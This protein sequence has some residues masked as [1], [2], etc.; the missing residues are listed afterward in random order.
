MSSTNMVD[1]E[2]Q[3]TKFK[4]CVKIWETNFMKK[5][6]RK[7]NKT[8]INEAS[9]TIRDAYKNY[10]TLKT[11]LL[12]NTVTDAMC[13]IPVENF[14]VGSKNDSEDCT[15]DDNI[16]HNKIQNSTD[17]CLCKDLVDDINTSEQNRPR[18]TFISNFYYEHCK[19]NDNSI[20][21]KSTFHLSQN[22]FDNFCGR[23]PTKSNPKHDNSSQNQ[24]NNIFG[25][26]LQN[27][28]IQN[29]SIP[30]ATPQKVIC[31]PKNTFQQIMERIPQTYCKQSYVNNLNKFN[32][33]SSCAEDGKSETSSLFDMNQFHSE[34]DVVQ[35]LFIFMYQS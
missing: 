9:S 18:Q 4:T 19:K 2:K 3:Y 17:T 15:E 28:Q 25:E 10:R 12:E 33:F 6:S 13:S 5:N 21:H 16:Y 8:D 27:E 31:K 7:P 22:R 34:K 30:Y 26:L 23:Y 20:T 11:K 29:S 35:E 1:L 32:N 24:L 14:H